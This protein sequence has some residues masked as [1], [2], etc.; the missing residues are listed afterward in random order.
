MQTPRPASR[1]LVYHTLTNKINF[2]D[3]VKKCHCYLWHQFHIQQGQCPGGGVG[4]HFLVMG[5]R[6]CAAGRGSRLTDCNGVA[7]SGI[8]N[9]V[10]RMGSQCFGTLRVRKSFAEKCLRWGLLLLAKQKRLKIDYSGV[11][12]LRCQRHIPS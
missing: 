9:K 4:G 3:Q 1:E 5:Y 8:F 10:T 6:G 2:K 11:V 12:V 7:I